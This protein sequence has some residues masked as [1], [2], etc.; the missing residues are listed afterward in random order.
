MV[1]FYKIY[2]KTAV[3]TRA[4]R[5]KPTSFAH[6]VLRIHAGLQ[7]VVRHKVASTPSSIAAFAEQACDGNGA[8]SLVLDN[9]GRH[10]VSDGHRLWRTGGVVWCAICGCHTTRRLRGLAERCG[11]RPVQQIARRNLAEGKLPNARRRDTA[12]TAPVRLTVEA[13]WRWKHGDSPGAFE[14]AC[15]AACANG[16]V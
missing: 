4:K 15:E 2:Y 1:A 11:A 9:L 14:L 13:W 10:A 16:C 3:T 12:A 7:C 5:A 6:Q 8:S